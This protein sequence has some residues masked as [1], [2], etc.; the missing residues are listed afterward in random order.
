MVL[1]AALIQVAMAGFGAEIRGA[2]MPDATT[3]RVFAGASRF[4]RADVDAG[5]PDT[6]VRTIRGQRYVVLGL[7][8]RAPTDGSVAELRPV[9]TFRS[10]VQSLSARARARAQ[11]PRAVNYEL[12][13]E[14]PFVPGLLAGPTPEDLDV[15]GPAGLRLKAVVRPG[16]TV[17]HCVALPVESG[18]SR[19]QL[20]YH[21]RTDSVQKPTR[22]TP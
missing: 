10:R 3:P 9:E 20:D 22:S 18:D 13:L 5:D 15:V 19:I 7:D 6:V 11:A 8:V 17:R 14:A 12:W 16:A 2:V 4:A 1:A 21:F